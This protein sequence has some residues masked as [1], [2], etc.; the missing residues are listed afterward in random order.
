MISGAPQAPGTNGSANGTT[1][2]TIEPAPAATQDRA[3]T[4]SNLE[5]LFAADPGERAQRLDPQGA[6]L[7]AESTTDAPAPADPK[8]SDATT[9]TTGSQPKAEPAADGLDPE[10]QAALDRLGAISPDALRKFLKAQHEHPLAKLTQGEAS[11]MARAAQQ[12][13]T[14]AAQAKEAAETASRAQAEEFTKL[15]KTIQRAAQTEDWPDREEARNELLGPMFDQFQRYRTLMDPLVREQL[16][17]DVQTQVQ[18]NLAAVGRDAY[19]QATQQATTHDAWKGLPEAAFEAAS[20]TVSAPDYY[21]ALYA[22]R[23]KKDGLLTPK[24]ADDLVKQALADDRATGYSQIP[25]HDNSPSLGSGNGSRAFD[26]SL[27]ADQLIASALSDPS[28]GRR[29]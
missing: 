9:A 10:L 14:E 18:A 17:S 6:P 24:Q 22:A 3:A 26:I 23:V 11:N 2:P 19:V 27:P 15:E 13:A 29:S 8:A 25:P 4:L 12:R 1:T 20:K 28:R 16:A 7:P 21:D 5:T